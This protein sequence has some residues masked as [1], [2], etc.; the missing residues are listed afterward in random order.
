M[1][2]RR[3]RRSSPALREAR[4]ATDLLFD[5]FAGDVVEL[6]VDAGDLVERIYAALERVRAALKT[7][8]A[9]E[10]AR[11]TGLAST[12][13]RARR[14][15]GNDTAALVVHLEREGGLLGELIEWLR[16][17][18]EA[19]PH[20]IGIPAITSLLINPPRII[21][22]S[23]T[24]VLLGL[25]CPR[26]RMA[27]RCAVLARWRVRRG[28]SYVEASLVGVDE[29]G[30][31]DLE[32]ARLL[33]DLA[34][35]SRATS[36]VERA[37]AAVLV[38]P[39]FA[40]VLGDVDEARRRLAALG[41]VRGVATELLAVD[42]ERNL[43]AVDA[44]LSAPEL[45]IVFVWVEPAAQWAWRRAREFDARGGQLIQL[46]AAELDGALAQI[47]AAL[48][49]I[50]AGAGDSGGDE[51]QSTLTDVQRSEVRALL[52]QGGVRIVFVG[53][54]E[55]QAQYHEGIERDLEGLYGTGITVRWFEGWGSSWNAIERAAHGQMA[56]ADSVVVMRMV[57]T[58]LGASIRRRAGELGLPWVA[59]QGTGRQ[60]LMA[61]L[62]QALL[63]VVRGRDSAETSA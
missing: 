7:Q 39:G 44:A 63:V 11:Y 50:V 1:G 4:A 55:T 37:R 41:V 13:D 43:A 33:T 51:A 14:E 58:L 45:D 20:G 3:N 23:D 26:G 31:N 24:V 59:C 36:S 18:D 48:A 22:L 35:E 62:E 34:Y 5:R 60:S 9:T 28:G 52:A 30:G 57:R 49:E 47:D 15:V 25:F 46:N 56:E 8:S 27:D 6:D 12:L 10:L 40:G 17:A 29:P 19:I 16:L 53:G 38:S 61:S 54:N 32:I 42:D 21:D 2:G